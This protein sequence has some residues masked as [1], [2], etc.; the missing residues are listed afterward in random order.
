MH[1]IQIVNCWTNTAIKISIVWK[2]SVK[3]CD[4]IY[5]IVLIFFH[6]I[7]RSNHSLLEHVWISSI[8]NGINIFENRFYFNCNLFFIT[9]NS[10]EIDIT[11]WTKR[12]AKYDGNDWFASKI[13]K[14]WH[15]TIIITNF[16]LVWWHV[17]W[18]IS[19]NTVHSMQLL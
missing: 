13:R 1:C 8:K 3:N 4:F 10:Y 18:N 9:A 6:K 14:Q 17:W 19:S 2:K 5:W 12:F 7:Q 15:E 11:E 16:Q